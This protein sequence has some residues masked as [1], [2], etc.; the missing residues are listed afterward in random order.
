MEKKVLATVGEKEITNLDV[1]GILGGLD[2]LSSFS[3]QL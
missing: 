3:L 2:P 1:E